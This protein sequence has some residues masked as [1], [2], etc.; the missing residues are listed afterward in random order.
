MIGRNCGVNILF[1]TF[2]LGV[3]QLL[4]LVFQTVLCNIAWCKFGL[5]THFES[6]MHHSCL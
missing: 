1:L 3:A 4:T 6:E 5:K 2:P